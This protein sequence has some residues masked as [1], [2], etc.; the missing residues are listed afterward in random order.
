MI[1]LIDKC[2][3]NIL[4]RINVVHLTSEQLKPITMKHLFVPY[5]L[6]LLAKEKGFPQHIG[7]GLAAYD[8]TEDGTE[9]LHTGGA[10]PVGLLVAPLYQQLIDWFREKH[11][12]IIT[13]LLYSEKHAYISPDP[14]FIFEFAISD[15]VNGNSSIAKNKDYYES[16][17]KALTEAFKL[18]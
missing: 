7:S 8:K 1:I 15:H 2:K 11:L 4:D 17:N 6:A 12:I 18:I 5:E 3:F 10:Y 13:P 16:F 9:W 14:N